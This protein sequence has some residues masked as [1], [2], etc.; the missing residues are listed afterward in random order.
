VRGI[1]KKM[2]LLPIPILMMSL[3]AGLAMVTPTFANPTT[4]YIDPRPNGPGDFTI[5]VMVSDVVDLYGYE[6]KVLF[7]PN[8]LTVSDSVPH[9]GTYDEIPIFF[10]EPV[11]NPKLMVWE[12][13]ACWKNE[14]GYD[15]VWV[16]VTRP[17]GTASG[18]TGSGLLAT[19]TFTVNP[20]ASGFTWLDL[21]NTLMG[22]PFGNPISHTVN[23]G[24]FSTTVPVVLSADLRKR[25]ST[26]R[27]A[28]YELVLSVDGSTQTLLGEVMN[29]GNVPIYARVY[30]VVLDEE[31]LNPKEGYSEPVCLLPGESAVVTWS[32][33]AS[34]YVNQKV[35]VT[36]Y[37]QFESNAM[38][39]GA[40]GPTTRSYPFHVLP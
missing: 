28:D 17:Y 20:G 30:F 38:E 25:R 10:D 27:P 9:A 8:L 29:L 32:F 5:N 22:D 12:Y 13:Y 1:N 6:F 11:W 21:T 2:M 19:I 33:D 15:Y 24:Y 34:G 26:N 7:D 18:K 31:M 23:D 36:N 37:C 3:F 40:T 14:I 16:A 4:M 35:H 39:F